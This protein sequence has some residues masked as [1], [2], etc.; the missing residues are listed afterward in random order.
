MF[1]RKHSDHIYVLCKAMQ[2]KRDLAF[3]EHLTQQIYVASSHSIYTLVST[4]RCDIYFSFD[5]AVASFIFLWN[6][7][8]IIACIRAIW[9]I[10]VLSYL[11][12]HKFSMLSIMQWQHETILRNWQSQEDTNAYQRNVWRKW[13]LIFFFKI[14]RLLCQKCQWPILDFLVVQ[15]S[16]CSVSFCNMSN[17]LSTLHEPGY[18]TSEHMVKWSSET[19]SGVVGMFISHYK[20]HALPGVTASTFIT[21]IRLYW[22]LHEDYPKQIINYMLSTCT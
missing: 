15:T 6:T 11:C 22:I 10:F 4:N 9:Y 21:P 1:Q 13:I 7:F 8:D 20:D 5:F 17:F 12:M 16:F 18:S 14:L 3:Y 19:S 2:H